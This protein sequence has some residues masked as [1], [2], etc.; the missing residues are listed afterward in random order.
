MLKGEHGY[1]GYKGEKVKRA[2]SVFKVQLAQ[3]AHRVLLG[4]KEQLVKEETW[5]KKVNQ[6]TKA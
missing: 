3:L 2:W 5:A 1:P 6:A 4:Y